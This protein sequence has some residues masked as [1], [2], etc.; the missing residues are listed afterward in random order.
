MQSFT[1]QMPFLTLTTSNTLGFTFSACTTTPEG[2]G[3]DRWL[4]DAC[5]VYPKT[6]TKQWKQSLSEY[7]KQNV[8]VSIIR[9]NT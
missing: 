3:G 5:T 8:A 4:S 2:E 9:D 1:G 6:L 7:A